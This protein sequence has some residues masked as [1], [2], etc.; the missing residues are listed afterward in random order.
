MMMKIGG[1]INIIYIYNYKSIIYSYR[2]Q[3]FGFMKSLLI[4][5]TYNMIMNANL[6][7]SVECS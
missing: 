6:R 7:M 2:M 4:L 1:Y 5:F 3:Y